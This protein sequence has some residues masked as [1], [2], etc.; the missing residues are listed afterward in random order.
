V[1]SWHLGGSV[2]LEFQKRG[3]LATSGRLMRGAW[4]RYAGDRFGAGG[5][6]RAQRLRQRHRP[7]SRIQRE[8]RADALR[9]RMS[10][11]LALAP[12]SGK[13]RT[14]GMR[15]GNERVLHRRSSESRWP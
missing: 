15:E 9:L 4:L 8:T 14:T 11:A 1:N 3:R 10:I 12:F 6:S 7:E 2:M 5:H 13:R